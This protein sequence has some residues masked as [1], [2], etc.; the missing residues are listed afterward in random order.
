MIPKRSWPLGLV[1]ILL[2]SPAM[3]GQKRVKANPR[4]MPDGVVERGEIPGEYKWRPK[5]LFPTEGA[6]RRELRAV[7]ASIDELARYKGKL[8]DAGTIKQALTQRTELGQRLERLYSYAHRLHDADTRA[9]GP[10]AL[11][12]RLEPV[13]ARLSATMSFFRPELLSLPDNELRDLSRHP[14]LKDYNLYLKGL[15]GEKKHVLS[16]TEE[17]LLAR[18]HELSDVGHDIFSTLSDS[19]F[20]FRPV[21]DE[22]GKEVELSEGNFRGFMDSADRSVRKGAY[23][24]VYATLHQFQNTLAKT[25]STQVK[26]AVIESE[27]RNHRTVRGAS[28]RGDQVS[29]KAYDTL[30]RSVGDHLPLLH[31]FLALKAE[32]L[33][34]DRLEYFD[35]NT[36]AV[37][38]KGAQLDYARAREMVIDAVAP[39]GR[40]YQE[41]LSKGLEPGSGWVDVFPTRG[42]R[43]GAYSAGGF[44]EHPFVLL[45][46]QGTNG[47]ASTL[48]HE[49][50]H[51]M[52][53]LYSHETQPA[54]KA[55]YSLIVAETASTLN[56]E[57]LLQKHLAQ[58]T[59]RH[60]RLALLLA[61]LQNF[62]SCFFRQAM[63]AEFEH[64]VYRLGQKRV[65]L[66]A[67]VLDDTY[68]KLL[69]RYGG[70]DAGVTQIDDQFGVE[71]A[72]I[73]HFYYGFYVYKYVMGITA[74]T[75]LVAKIASEG[76]PAR[77]R[78]LKLLQAGGSDQPLALLRRAGVDFATPQ[79]YQLAMRS[80][81]ETLAEAKKLAAELGLTKPRI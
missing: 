51:A 36:P 44:H 5:D 40:E 73:P 71:W 24:S 59:D 12:D 50:G 3:A 22:T 57:L 19:D 26:E 8:T 42:K 54:P 80:F 38:A 34:L 35:F 72:R 81:A 15:R 14:E 17:R 64:M 75:A 46:F 63:F 18:I 2:H 4:F 20:H 43:S 48:A 29:D 41:R 68:L 65:P 28:L 53:S 79:P 7:D 66:T 60:E 27:V 47:G 62:Q 13:A 49:M 31:D 78:Y 45:N 30:I 70:H 23:D 32:L 16:P 10:R 67:E 25:L 37:Q 6:F 52:H 55:E 77:K 9:A 76:E 56:E 61:R 1:L 74:S 39:L 69:R 21:R 33:G 58:T 11:V